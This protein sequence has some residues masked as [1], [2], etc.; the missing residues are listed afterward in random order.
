MERRG[1]KKI[2]IGRMAKDY[3]RKEM[4]YGCKRSKGRKEHGCMFR[5][6]SSCISQECKHYQMADGETPMNIQQVLV[7]QLHVNS[8]Y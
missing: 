4:R 2:R 3:R 1:R 6:E 5:T 7:Y 8:C